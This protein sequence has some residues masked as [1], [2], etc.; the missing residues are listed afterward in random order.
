M[1]YTGIRHQW[2]FRV[3][4]VNVNLKVEIK[5]AVNFKSKYVPRNSNSNFKLKVRLGVNL[6]LKL[7]PTLSPAYYYYY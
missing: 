6:N 2:Q 4:V 3:N 1:N 7:S 5:H